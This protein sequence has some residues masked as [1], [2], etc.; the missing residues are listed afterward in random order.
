MHSYQNQHQQETD[1]EDQLPNSWPYI[2]DSIQHQVLAS[3]PPGRN[4]LTTQSTRQTKF[5]ASSDV[6]YVTVHSS[7]GSR[8]F[9]SSETRARILLHSLG[10][11]PNHRQ[12]HSQHGTRVA[13][14]C[15]L[16]SPKLYRTDPSMCLC[17]IWFFTSSQQFFSY[18]GT[19]FLGWT[20][21]LNQY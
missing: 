19:V 5:A 1:L 9:N 11:S 3:T 7:E 21:R 8:L 15:P 14:G 2:G 13:Q 6:T 16:R 10:P 17:L 4:T 18:V 20:P 12:S